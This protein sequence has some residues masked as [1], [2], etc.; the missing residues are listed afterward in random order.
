MPSTAASDGRGLV[1]VE[2]NQTIHEACARRWARWA[3]GHGQRW[4]GRSQGSLWL[5]FALLERFGYEAPQPLAEL[6]PSR[7][8][9]RG[10]AELEQVFGYLRF[11]LEQICCHMEMESCCGPR[12][13]I[14]E[15]GRDGDPIRNPGVL[16][17]PRNITPSTPQSI[18]TRG[19]PCRRKV[20][21][22][23]WIERQKAE[24]GHPGPKPSP[25]CS[26]APTTSKTYGESLAD[27]LWLS[28]VRPVADFPRPVST[29][30]ELL[31]AEEL[32]P[33][34]SMWCENVRCVP[35][36]VHQ[37]DGPDDQGVKM[38]AEAMRPLEMNFVRSTAGSSAAQGISRGSGHVRCSSNASGSYSSNVKP[39]RGEQHLGGGRNL[40][41]CTS[42]RKTFAFNA[43]NP[44]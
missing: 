1:D 15:P 18:P 10:S 22:I 44:E 12:W 7:A 6:L 30:L 43:D 19:P 42:H 38:A 9:G 16:A 33:P 17:Q 2:L 5:F 3:R 24:A 23:A 35:R 4:A 32:G 26:G 20:G 21:W 27:F 11:C 31:L 8:F 36:S 39:G 14:R 25:A 34:A 41:E 13:R 28:G 37:P 29:S 40:Q